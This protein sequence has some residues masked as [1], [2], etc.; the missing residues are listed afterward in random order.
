MG[1]RF[2]FR[3]WLLGA[4]APLALVALTPS[5]V[6]AADAAQPTASSTSTVTATD[7]AQSSASDSGGSVVSE[8]IVTGSNIHGVA[9][10]GSTL[11][12]VGS[13]DIA[14]SGAITTQ[15]LLQQVPEVFNLGINDTSRAVSSGSSNVG[16]GSSV[17]LRG[18][19][20]YATLTLVDG[21]RVP[22]SGTLGQAFDPS[23]IP[24]LALERVE[25]VADGSSGIY[26][27]DAIAGVVN[28]IL[29][30]DFDGLEARASYGAA[31]GYNQ[32]TLGFIAGH[33]WN[34]GNLTVS[35]ENTFHTR[36]TGPSRSFFTAN[37]TS[38]G[39]NDYRISQCSPGNI[40]IG[41]VS[42]AIPAGGVTPATASTLVA[43]TK[44][45]CSPITAQDI[46]P[47]QTHYSVA[48]TFHQDIG[49]RIHFT[50]DAYWYRRELIFHQAQTTSTFNVPS[51][52]A[53]F[54]TPPGQAGLASESVSYSFATDLGPTVTT[55]G[56][57]ESY[58]VHLGADFDLP[59]DWKF[60]VSGS[61]GRDIS[62][63][64]T[65]RLNTIALQA[66]LASSNP[67]TAL[68]PFSGAT[69]NTSSSVLAGLNTSVFSPTG[70]DSMQEVTANLD[71]AL[72]NLPGGPV[73]AAFG[74][75]YD[76]QGWTFT[77][78][79]GPPQAPS[80][81]YDAKQRDVGAGYVEVLIPVVGP[82][83][84]APLVQSL[85]IDAA[86]RYS[87][88][89]SI[90]STTNPKIGVNWAPVDG[91]VIHGSYGTSFRAP[92]L[93]D[94][95]IS[96][97]A[98]YVMN[99]PDPKSPTGSTIG[100]AR[101]GGNPNLK[102]ETAKTYS[103]G[104]DYSPP[105]IP[106]LKL[107]INYF[108]ID[109]SNQIV[110]FLSNTAIL[111]QESFYS[112]IITRNPTPAQVTAFEGNL[113]INGVPPANPTLLVDGA[114]RNLGRSVSQGLDLSGSYRFTTERYGTFQVS[115]AG[116]Y[117]L[118]Y[119]VQ[120]T[121]T[122][123]LTSALN[124][125]Y[126]PLRFKMRSALDWQFDGFDTNVALNYVNGY[127]NTLSTPKQSVSPYTTVDLHLSYAVD[128]GSDWLKGLRVGID[129][130]NLFDAQ[131]PFVNIAPSGN[132]GGGFDPTVANP[133]GR[134][135]AFYV[136]KKW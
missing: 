101:S 81:R 87:N 83:N 12:S 95:T 133:I 46:V 78:L 32:R 33:S 103:V 107:G 126:N 115:A 43:G 75:Q 94:A 134:I 47:Q 29:K 52:N 79:N 72:F 49:D 64:S 17:N 71:G 77:Y 130:T 38:R 53:F 48:A 85:N 114:L 20:P 68:D 135:V 59:H 2:G 44:N 82:D 55:N 57:V 3:H 122:A 37:L 10:V 4:S 74:I 99:Y 129:V 62:S 117:M 30:K 5:Q 40:T 132:G 113:F 28:L 136:D 65:F 105:S 121:P 63:V 41:G 109:Y 92:L 66:A 111:N 93:S 14:R 88:Y 123:P 36:L 100:I 120:Q 23:A 13:P 91:L 16:Y 90:G 51:S 116:T 131:P 89:S 86:A 35:F 58:N 8:V 21:H 76:H 69:S 106:G 110:Q 19:G 96:T 6:L 70:T 7:T 18:I 97:A 125:I 42:Y 98:L 26:G 119:L 102:P 108:D 73:R 112:S 61:V 1:S 27:S 124:T 128:H 54:V 127:T 50:G 24:T 39:G 45:L 22:V 60:T 9:P 104:A 34:G 31:D 80:N 84:S 56:Y 25:I 11:I 118:E 67:A 15:D